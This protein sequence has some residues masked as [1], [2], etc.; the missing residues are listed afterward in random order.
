MI[1]NQSFFTIKA[2]T[3]II[4]VPSKSVALTR[5][6]S[7]KIVVAFIALITIHTR[8]FKFART[9]SCFLVARRTIDSTIAITLTSCFRYL[10]NQILISGLIID[11]LFLRKY[12]LKLV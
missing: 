1:S 2:Y 8:K 10:P 9:F 3:I 11:F 6:A 5:C 7:R 4:A 12:I